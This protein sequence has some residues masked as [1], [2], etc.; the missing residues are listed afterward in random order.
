MLSKGLFAGIS[1]EGVVLAAAARSNE[2][3]YGQGTRPT[4][5]LVTR[6]VSNPGSEPLR[7]AVANAMK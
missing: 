4:D 6:T 1:V 7:A 3:Y 2:A 5:I